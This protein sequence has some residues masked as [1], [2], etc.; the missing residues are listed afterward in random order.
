MKGRLELWRSFEK[1]IRAVRRFR[2]WRDGFAS[3]S[4]VREKDSGRF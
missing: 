1:K 2:D 3:W 4:E